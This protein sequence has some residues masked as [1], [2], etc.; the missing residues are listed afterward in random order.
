MAN[1]GTQTGYG[2][3]GDQNQVHTEQ[4]LPTESTRNGGIKP[5][6]RAIICASSGIF[7]FCGGVLT[8]VVI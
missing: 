8:D 3:A 1:R 4:L 2:T 7:S 6:V 5:C